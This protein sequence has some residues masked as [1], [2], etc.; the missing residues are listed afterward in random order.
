MRTLKYKGRHPGYGLIPFESGPFPDNPAAFAERKV[1][2]DG[3]DEEEF[4]RVMNCGQFDQDDDNDD[5]SISNNLS[6]AAV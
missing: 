6:T 1:D 2:D 4:D 5:A 3:G